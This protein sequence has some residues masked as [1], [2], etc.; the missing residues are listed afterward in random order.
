MIILMT[1]S[2]YWVAFI[3]VDK[4]IAEKILLMLVGVSNAESDSPWCPVALI[5]IR[6]YPCV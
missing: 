5:I 6:V 1:I 3:E 2:N 4:L